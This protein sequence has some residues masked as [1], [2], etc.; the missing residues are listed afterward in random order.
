M[1]T[2]AGVVDLTQT[3]NPAWL[4]TKAGSG[5][6]AAAPL[7]PELLMARIDWS[8]CRGVSGQQLA[9]L[10][11][12]DPTHDVM[13][14]PQLVG[15]R[16]GAKTRTNSTTGMEAKVG[17]KIWDK[18]SGTTG[19]EDT[20]TTAFCIPH[21][22]G[23]FWSPVSLSSPTLCEGLQGW[24][25]PLHTC[26]NGYNMA[27]IKETDNNKHQLPVAA[28]AKDHKLNGLKQQNFIIA[29]FGKLG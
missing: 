6:Q 14:A 25:V 8:I 10:A 9:I 16:L 4:L 5:P 23:H 11:S 26:E 17:K 13:L 15:W 24:S 7:S 22:L 1:A 12:W 28:I 21:L 19:T 18:D 2:R 29:Q 3:P 20:Y 27:I